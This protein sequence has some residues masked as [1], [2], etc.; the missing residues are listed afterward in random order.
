[1][2]NGE[3]DT[4]PVD[5]LL[6]LLRHYDID[7]R[8]KAARVLSGHGPEAVESLLSNIYDDDEEIRLLTI[9]ALGRIGDK[10]AIEYINRSLHDENNLVRF[11]SEGAISRLIRL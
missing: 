7:T 9:W 8:W 11:A 2:P 3:I 1:M 10:R 4:L 6:G 5:E